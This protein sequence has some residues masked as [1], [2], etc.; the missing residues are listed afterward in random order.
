[1]SVTPQGRSIQSLYRDYRE[2]RLMVNR[3]YQ[4]KLVWSA[5]EKRQLIDS[6]MKG[7]PIPLILLAERV[8]AY[9]AGRLEIIDGIQRLNAVF[10]F[11]ENSFDHEGRYFDVSE[12]TRARQAADEHVFEPVTDKPLLSQDECARFLDYQLAVSIYPA[13]RETDITDVFG[14]I[15]SGGRQLSPQEQRQAGVVSDFARLVRTLGSEFRG[16]V[17]K[18]VLRL[19]EMPEIS[20]DSSR[21]PHGYG[22]RAEQTFW[23][24]Q[25]IL[26]TKQLKESEDEQTI[27]DFAASILLGQPLAAS[28]ERLDSIYDSETTEGS[29]VQ[30]R[31]AAYGPERIAREIKATFSALRSVIESSNDSPNHL[32]SIVRPGTKYPIKAPFYA[33][34]MAFFDLVVRQQKSPD[35]P[36]RILQALNGLDDR[37]SKGAH[38]ETAEN[39]RGNIDLTKGLIQDFFVT[40]TP[41]VLG[42][43]EALAIDVE[44]CLRRSRIE[45]SRYEFKQGI[46]RLDKTR[47]VDTQLLSRLPETACGIA[48]LGP[49]SD[50]FIFLGIADRKEHADRIAHFDGIVPQLVADHYIV[51]IDREA[52]LLGEDIDQFVRRIVGAFQSSGLTEPL[53]TQILSSF[54]AV[55]LHGL[56]VV[57]IRIPRQAGVSLVGDQAFSREGSSTVEVSGKRLVAITQLFC[58]AG[59]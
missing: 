57:Q 19:F 43:G 11:I 33:I 39:R 29:D 40:K 8:D 50:G 23:C 46:L 20:V 2:G 49:E 37:L 28:K 7:Y 51:G 35:Q 25:G 9:D 36:T 4:R 12:F 58:R 55:T 14:R 22:V 48:N 24:R 42:R 17:S 56:T 21:E 31:L 32:R 41:A 26:S 5:G 38:Y 44:N 53:K 3:T 59:A 45:T 10:T 16:D 52:A 18:D 27:A 15:N 47:S 34:F 54:D 30:H 6:I 13:A 1:M